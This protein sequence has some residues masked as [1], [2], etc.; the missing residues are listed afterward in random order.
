MFKKLTIIIVTSLLLSFNANAGS[1][2]Q[3][4]LTKEV[5]QITDYKNKDCFEMKNAFKNAHI[6]ALNTP[7]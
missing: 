1:D 6:L 7:T 4:E 5:E 3:L 2:G